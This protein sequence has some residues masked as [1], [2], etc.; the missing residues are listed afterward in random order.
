MK[1]ISAADA[2]KLVQSN[3]TVVIS[4]S[5]GGHA[6]PE[7]PLAEIETPLP[8]RRPAARSHG[9]PRRR[10]RRP[11][12]RQRRRPFRPRRPDQAQRHQRAG[13]FAAPRPAGA[14]EQDRVLHPAAGRAVAAD[15]RHRRRPARPHHQDRPAY[16]RR[17]APAAARARAKARRKTWSSSSTIGG[18][19][20]L[21]FK[22]LPFDIAFLRGTTADEDGN[23]TMEQE[24]MFG[25]MLSMAQATRRNGGIVVVQVKRMARAR[26]AARR[27]T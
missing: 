15:A 22:P 11:Q 27:R 19:E 7:A 23:V 13:R 20:W 2:A 12:D 18:E 3:F 8:G 17:S 1:L 24:A 9:L 26:H 16:L 21:R 4:G 14:R 25:E 10:H 5:G 6:V